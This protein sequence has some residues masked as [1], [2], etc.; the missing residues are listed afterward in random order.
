M[1]PA[2]AV[3]D[4]ITNLTLYHL[5]HPDDVEILSMFVKGNFWTYGSVTYNTNAIRV[6]V[7]PLASPPQ[8]NNT[9]P[10]CAS[11]ADVVEQLP[12]HPSYLQAQHAHMNTTDMYL[13]LVGLDHMTRSS[14]FMGV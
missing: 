13:K 12:T 6:R 4:M 1:F 9:K 11:A 2:N 5:I 3:A 7:A 14:L 10:D 8:T